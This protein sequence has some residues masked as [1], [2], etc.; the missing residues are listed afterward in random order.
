[1][2]KIVYSKEL[3]C[4]CTTCYEICPK[5]A[6]EM[7]ADEEGFLYPF[8]NSDKCIKCGLCE[9]KCAFNHSDDYKNMFDVQA[10]GVK[11]KLEEVRSA[12]RSGGAFTV[13]SDWVLE[14]N[15]VVYGAAYNDEY[16]VVHKR[17]DSKD[18][19]NAFRGSK[20]VQSDLTNIFPMIKQD[21]KD[22][23]D[24][25]FTGVACQVAGLYAYLDKDYSNLFT[26]DIVCHG[27]P[28]PLIWEEYVKWVNK[29]HNGTIEFIDFRS[30]QEFGWT[31]HVEKFVING[32]NYYSTK[33]RQLF[34]EDSVLRPSCYNCQYTSINRPADFTIADFWGYPKGEFNDNKGISLVLLNNQKAVDVFE[35]IKDD[36]TYVTY[37]VNKLVHPNLKKPTKEPENRSEFW[38]TFNKAGIDGIITKYTMP[39]L[40]EKGLILANYVKNKLK[41]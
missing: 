14:N 15:G 40:I 11:H 1:M 3:C 5:H 19:R 27:V 38:E 34:Y 22:G 18:D 28:S 23:K 10:Y 2:Q 24:V 33:F 12:S 31:S 37:D 20:Y 21:L 39:D 8:I 4:G 30:K 17:A 7:K 32:K 25:L 13:I 16:R 29:R 35:K 26:C 6:I 36:A 9:K 41:I